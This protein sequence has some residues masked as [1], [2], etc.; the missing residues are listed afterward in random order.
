VRGLHEGL[1]AVKD[2]PACGGTR[3]TPHL[4]AGGWVL[5][6]CP[7]CGLILLNPRPAPEHYESGRLEQFL[8]RT[9]LERADA[10]IL[11]NADRVRQLARFTRVGTLCDVGAGPGFFMKAAERAGWTAMGCDAVVECASFGRERLG[12]AALT[13][14]TFAAAFERLPRGLDAVTLFHS[15]EH[16]VDPLRELRRA[17]VLLRPGGIVAIEVPDIQSEEARS[18]GPA[19]GHLR[20]PFHLYF[21]TPPSMGQ[22]MAR[23]G[24]RLLD[25][26]PRTGASPPAWFL[27]V[28]G[29]KAQHTG[30]TGGAASRR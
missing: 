14:G 9:V 12:L 29:Q 10:E 16:M 4:R 26:G 5:V 24:F 2:C 20:L 7:G 28:F 13:H 22:L 1:I 19:W 25:I 27:R 15:L 21:F 11:A 8:D 6:E 3:F 18:L 17:W 23:A 30:P